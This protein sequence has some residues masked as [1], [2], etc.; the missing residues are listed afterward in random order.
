MYYFMDSLLRKVVIEGM[1][2]QAMPS[3]TTFLIVDK[4]VG[5]E[6]LANAIF[7]NE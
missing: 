6:F 7:T 1:G 5:F 4:N 2:W 3:I